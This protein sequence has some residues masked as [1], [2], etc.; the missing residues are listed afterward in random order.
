VLAGAVGVGLGFG[1]QNVTSN[2]VSG[3]IILIERPIKVGD[4]IEIGCDQRR[5]PRDRSAGH[6]N[7]HE[8]NIAVI[9]RTRSS[10]P[11]ASPTGA[12]RV[13]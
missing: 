4:R 9:V 1:L 2:F 10:S 3:L 5:G 12:I 13:R 6:D 8:A 11:S 7:R